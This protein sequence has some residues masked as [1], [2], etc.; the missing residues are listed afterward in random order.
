MTESAYKFIHSKERV[1]FKSW[2]F[3]ITKLTENEDSVDQIKHSII[4]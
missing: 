4:E 3:R 2:Q 1:Q